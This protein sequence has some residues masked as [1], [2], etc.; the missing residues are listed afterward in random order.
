MWW[1]CSRCTRSVIERWFNWEQIH[2]GQ[3]VGEDP[4][5]GFYPP[6][7]DISEWRLGPVHVIDYC[8]SLSLGRHVLAI[9]VIQYCLSALSLRL[10]LLLSEANEHH[11]LHALSKYWM[12]CLLRKERIIRLIYY[13]Y[14]YSTTLAFSVFVYC[15]CNVHYFL[16]SFPTLVYM[17][18]RI[19]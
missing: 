18:V 5:D 16:N 10:N 17:F 6:W 8:L 11:K 4:S 2:T 15:Q 12:S 14:D 3:N 19:Q 13:Y 1:H 7:S 9:H